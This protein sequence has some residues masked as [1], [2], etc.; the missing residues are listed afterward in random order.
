MKAFLLAAGKGSRIS[1]SIPDIPKCTLDVAGKPLI[2]RTVEMLKKRDVDITVV[3]GYRHRV[4]EELLKDYAVNIV[5]NPFY[6][7]TNSIGS[8]WMAKSYMERENTIIANA[9]VYWNEDIL[10][11][12][13]SSSKDNVMLADSARVLDG[14][15]FF[16]QEHGKLLK[17]G[18]ELELEERNCEYVG[19]AFMKSNFVEEFVL[20]LEQMVEKQVYSV[21]W[22]NVFYSFIGEKDINII[23]INGHFWAE[24]DFIED[25]KRILD[26]VEQNEGD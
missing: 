10:D 7:V 18:K 21:W 1:K 9:D 4:I 20:R 8:L 5:Y 15:Y 3:V 19:L 14:D 2:I 24:I 22:E 11:V 12:L 25:Y 16:F 17:Y 26:Y 23:D 13:L 6:D